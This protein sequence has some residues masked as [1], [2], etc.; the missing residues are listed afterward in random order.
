MARIDDVLD[1][2]QKG[3]IF[4]TLDLEDGFFH[5]PVAEDSRKYTAFVTPDGQYEFKYVPFGICNSPAVF[6]RFISFVLTRW[7]NCSLYG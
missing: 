4:T 7:N 5:V 3:K 1:R 2:L 6:C